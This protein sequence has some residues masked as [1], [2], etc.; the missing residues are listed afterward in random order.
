[1]VGR[2]FGLVEEFDDRH[3]ECVEN[4]AVQ[5]V[6]GGMRRVIM[7]FAEA[8]FGVSLNNFKTNTIN[9]KHTHNCSI[10][11]GDREG[12]QILRSVRDSPGLRASL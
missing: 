8:G 2:G 6:L 4:V 1:M 12:L 7:V 11:P 9:S 10:Q 3:Q 5:N